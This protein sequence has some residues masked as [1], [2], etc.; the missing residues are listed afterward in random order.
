MVRVK[1]LR[2]AE[3]A[4]KQMDILIDELADVEIKMQELK[5]SA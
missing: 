5:M 3:E 2:A 4:A 1:D